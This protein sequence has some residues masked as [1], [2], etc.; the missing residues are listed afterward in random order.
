MVC[1]KPF[2]PL[3]ITKSPTNHEVAHLGDFVISSGLGGFHEPMQIGL[4]RSNKYLSEGPEAESGCA[5][6]LYSVR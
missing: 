1:E 2:K 5:S 6:V 4:L 3:E